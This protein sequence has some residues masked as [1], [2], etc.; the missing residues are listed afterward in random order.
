[1]IK[2]CFLTLAIILF[3]TCAYA[4]VTVADKKFDNFN[5]DLLESTLKTSTVSIN[6]NTLLSNSEVFEEFIKAT[7]KFKQSNIGVAYDDYSLILNSMEENDLISTIM[8]E[9]LADYGLF[10]LSQ[11]ACSK[12]SDADITNKHVNNIKNFF[13]PKSQLP[14]NEEIYLAEAYSNIVYNNQSQETL[15]ELLKQKELLANYDYANYILALAAYKSNNLPIAQ[16]YIRIATTQNPKNIN[17]KVLEAQIL[18]NDT[19]PQDAFKIVNQLKKE[20]LTETAIIKKI[21]A[22]EQYVLYKCAKKDWEKNFYLGE[23]YYYESDY[24][25]SIKTFQNA[26]G[27]NKSINSKINGYISDVYLSMQDYEKAQDTALK[28]LKHDHNNPQANMTLGYINYIQKNYKK[29]LKNYKKAEKDKTTQIAAEIQI[30]KIL[31]KM[32]HNDQSKTLFEKIIQTYST[33]IE[34]YY[35]LAIADKNKEVEYLKKA[36]SLNILYVDAWLGLARYELSK[37]DLVKAENYL[38]TV[39]YIDK[40]DFRYYYYQGLIY[41]IKNDKNKAASYFE[42]CIKLNPSCNEAQKELKL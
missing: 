11:L 2:K 19:K 37:N 12:M 6:Y 26:L 42:K 39:Y 22:I 40:N 18:A 17:Y 33:E 24:A 9:K 38:S 20:N 3:S 21:N 31:N 8:A 30:A 5:L 15:K 4:D 27:K 14:Y 32:G 36:L 13:Y 29:A 1:M 10:S 35:N 41:K 28:A 25:K 23:Y 34:C 16:K 7:D